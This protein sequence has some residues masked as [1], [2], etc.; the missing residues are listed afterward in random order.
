MIRLF[1]LLFA[2]TP[3]F[4][5]DAGISAD[6]RVGAGLAAPTLIDGEDGWQAPIAGVPGGF[7]RV[8]R[9][10]DL[11]H[12]RDAFAFQAVAA[13][14]LAQAPLVGVGDEAVGD[15]VGFLV[16]RVGDRVFTIRDPSGDAKGRLKRLTLPLR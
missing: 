4:A 12:A 7:V 8:L 13:A 11:S 3:A 16:A 5:G 1:V 2:L 9:Y 6:L 10:P 14:N 15:G